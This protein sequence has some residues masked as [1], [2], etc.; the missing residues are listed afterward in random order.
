M[1]GW[2]VGLTWSPPAAP[3]SPPAFSA[4][5][6]F[7]AFALA[8]MPPMKPMAPPSAG[9]SPFS[10]PSA[11]AAPSAGTS[12]PSPSGLAPIPGIFSL[13]RVWA[14]E[15]RP[16]K[17]EAMVGEEVVGGVT[18]GRARLTTSRAGRALAVGGLGPAGLGLRNHP[19]TPRPT[20]TS[21]TT[22]PS[23]QARVAG[24]KPILGWG[25]CWRV[26]VEVEV[27]VGVVGGGVG[28]GGLQPVI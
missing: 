18:A 15:A 23:L 19:T 14:W 11:G 16:E 8:I 6:A 3:P 26:E 9:T 21:R 10:A 2:Q 28:G 13:T 22:T 27:V 17:K 25:T 5:A 1:E 12:P 7:T 4:A 24:G 20:P